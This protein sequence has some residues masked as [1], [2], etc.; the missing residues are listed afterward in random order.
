MTNLWRY[1][2]L[3]TIG[4]LAP[5]TAFAQ[6]TDRLIE[7]ELSRW[8]SY[9][10]EESSFGGG[11][12]IAKMEDDWFALLTL[13]FNWNEENWGFGLQA[14]V[15]IR[16]TNC[17]PTAAMVT[18]GEKAEGGFPC[19][20][21]QQI[22]AEEGVHRWFPAKDWDD[23]TDYFKLLRYVYI[24]RSDKKGSYY[25]RLGEITN[26]S[27][28]HGTM[29]HRYSNG[30]V[31]G[32]WRIGID[33]SLSVGPFAAELLIGDVFDPL[34]IGARIQVR[35]FALVSMA[36][37]DDEEKKDGDEDKPEPG[38]A[39][40][41]RFYVGASVVSDARAPYDLVRDQ[42]GDPQ[43]DDEGQYRVKDRKAVV[44]FGA[45][46]GIEVLSTSI[47]KIEPYM[48]FN[49]FTVLDEGWGLHIGVLWKFKVPIIIDDL[50]ADLRTEYRRVSGDYAAPYFDPLYEIERFAS[51]LGSPKV[52]PKLRRLDDGDLGGRNGIYAEAL[53]GLPQWIFLM[54]EYT[55][56]DGG[57][58]DGVLRVGLI[59]PALDW[60]KLS[61]FYYRTGISGLDDLWKLD[62]RSL[63]AAEVSVPIYSILSVNVR[64]WRTW[65]ATNQGYKADDDFSFNVGF[66]YAF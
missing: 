60:L 8:T 14:P 2:A 61:A 51:P 45:D 66:N 30:N 1:F 20:T 5:A 57:E 34:L 37:D 7:S 22:P 47:L 25:V 54:G 53:V 41:D 44:G 49:K 26:A 64:Y 13:R 62:D 23:W 32:R 63:L 33:G 6:A 18:A 59:V 40:L 24:G 35:P 19:S 46:V 36:S 48:D 4:A 42:N 10:P 55:D 17:R 27:L 21:P 29:A 50:V 39:I 31:Q 16:L 56:Y 58:A 9:S 38:G 11:A 15:R 3:T 65:E 43:L 12:G 52:Q 28:G